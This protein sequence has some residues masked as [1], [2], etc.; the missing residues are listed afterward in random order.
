MCSE[1]FVAGKGQ[2]YC[3]DP[4]LV[5]RIETDSGPVFDVQRGLCGGEGPSGDQPRGPVLAGGVLQG[6]RG[7]PVH[8][9]RRRRCRH[10]LALHLHQGEQ[11]GGAGRERGK[12][13]PVSK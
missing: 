11:E 1:D 5:R 3:T 6:V 13:V 10:T 9:Y 7:G 4:R 2:V 8:P 12:N